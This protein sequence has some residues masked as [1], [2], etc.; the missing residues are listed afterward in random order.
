MLRLFFD[1]VFNLKNMK[2]M[3]RTGTASRIKFNEN[4]FG[5]NKNEIEVISSVFL[6]EF[7]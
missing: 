2:T 6:F 4:I 7:S 3:P 1:L 5:K